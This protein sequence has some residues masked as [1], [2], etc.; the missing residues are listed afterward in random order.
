LCLFAVLGLARLGLAQPT[1]DLGFDGDPSGATV[2]GTPGDPYNLTATL[3][4]TLTTSGDT[5]DPVTEEPAGAQ[6]WSISVRNLEA[7]ITGITTDGTVGADVNADPPGLRNTG[8]EKSEITEGGANPLSCPGGVDG[9]VSAVVLSFT[10]PITLSAD[11]GTEVIAKIDVEAS[12]TFPAEGVQ[13]DHDLIEYADGCQG[14]GQPVGNNVT[15]TGQTI[16][17][18]LGKCSVTLEGIELVEDCVNDID[19]DGDELVDCAD[20][21]CAEHPAC[22]R[23]PLA[24]VPLQ[25]IIQTEGSNEQSI[26]EVVTEDGP[27]EPLSLTVQVPEA[28]VYAAIVSDDLRDALDQPSGVQGWSLSMPVDDSLGATLSDVTTD[29][30]VG[31]DINGDP[32][33]LRNTGFEKSELTAGAANPASCP[34]GL[35]GAVSAV[36]LSF[37]LP[38]TLEPTGTATVLAMTF[39]GE[40]GQ[41]AQ[42]DWRDGCQGSGQ[43]VNTVATVAGG[44]EF[45]ACAQAAIITFE[46]PQISPMIRCD[47]NADGK[48]N[49]ADAVWIVAELFYGGP[50]TACREASDCN[51]D[52]LTDLSDVVYNIG[53]RFLGE[54]PPPAPFPGC[55]VDPDS[56]VDSCPFGST[57]CE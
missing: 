46:A 48:V 35:D 11:P 47:A 27:D 6:G 4:C 43:P 54:S 9:A 39:A 50:P 17:P 49:I 25:L 2:G 22:Q 33:G 15:W 31:A 42:F 37:T 32:P 18:N 5:T 29:G 36:V 53:Y 26:G 56:T 12:A 24:G 21:D 8:F 30:T 57:S 13:E 14:S 45:Y 55:D 7:T 41:S 3:D 1:F 23:C 20:P 34:G 19:D 51:D 16:L 10:L 28:T 40:D 38:I 44:T 52:G